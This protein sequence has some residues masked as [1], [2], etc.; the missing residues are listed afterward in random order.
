MLKYSQQATVDIFCSSYDPELDFKQICN[1]IECE[2]SDTIVVWDGLQCMSGIDIST[3]MH[4][5]E[6]AISTAL[7]IGN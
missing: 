1:E 2:D 5:V 4:E 6:D 3:L 7:N